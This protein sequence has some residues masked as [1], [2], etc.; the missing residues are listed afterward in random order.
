M[1]WI[2]ID[3]VVELVPRDRIVS[4]KH[5][6]L[7]EE[8]LHD[9]FARHHEAA[10]NATG[11][12]WQPDDLAPN[13]SA[14]LIDCEAAKPIMPAS[15]I[16]EG[17]AQTAGILVGHASSFNDKPVL[18]KISKAEIHLDPT[19]GQTI[20]HTA[21]AQRL[22]RAGAAIYGT[23]EILTINRDGTTTAHHAADIDL[24]F[25]N[26]DQ[27]MGGHVFPEHNF[28]FSETFK[29]LLQLSGVEAPRG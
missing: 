14:T 21:T 15:L 5:I 17:M 6:S 28:V 10:P 16:I 13:S 1:R 8:H 27:N 24:M 29:T 12:W 19:P 7:A 25:S 11:G 23:V 3:R 20:R 2:W 26:L 9:H 4:I 18:A 22:D